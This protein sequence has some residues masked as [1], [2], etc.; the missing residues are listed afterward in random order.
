MHNERQLGPKDAKR[1]GGWLGE[2]GAKDEARLQ[3]Q[4]ASP[5]HHH[6][7]GQRGV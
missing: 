7:C 4:T 2:M 1:V 6:P 5:P 3:Q